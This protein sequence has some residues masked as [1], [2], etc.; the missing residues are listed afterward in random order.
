[1][2]RGSIEDDHLAEANFVAILQPDCPVERRPVHGGAVL[3]PEVF[4][5]GVPAVK[6]DAGMTT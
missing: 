4:Q 5:Y 3:A 1:M 6:N 2:C